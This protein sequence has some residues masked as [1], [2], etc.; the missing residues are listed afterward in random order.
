MLS[1]WVK[2]K[3]ITNKVSTVMGKGV[4]IKYSNICFKKKYI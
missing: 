2:F 1:L 3:I 4:R